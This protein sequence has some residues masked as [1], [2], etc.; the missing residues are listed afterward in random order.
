NTKTKISKLYSKKY[1]TPQQNPRNPTVQAGENIKQT[2]HKP[3]DKET[4]K[5]TKPLAKP[6]EG[7]KAYIITQSLTLNEQ[8]ALQQKSDHLHHSQC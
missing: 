6:C 3:T 1:H 7:E 8:S 4:A 5:K 2:T